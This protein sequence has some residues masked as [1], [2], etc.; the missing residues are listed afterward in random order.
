MIQEILLSDLLYFPRPT[1]TL[2]KPWGKF[3]ILLFS[4]TW[5]ILFIIFVSTAAMF[6]CCFQKAHISLEG[7]AIRFEIFHRCTY[8]LDIPRHQLNYISHPRDSSWL[9]VQLCSTLQDIIG[10]N[11]GPVPGQYLP[12]LLR[13]QK[14]PTGHLVEIVFELVLPILQFMRL[15]DISALG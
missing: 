6:G 2:S 13:I 4:N 14:F 3:R 7:G 10:L 15:G 9:M 8:L 1:K 12:I 11:I 5:P